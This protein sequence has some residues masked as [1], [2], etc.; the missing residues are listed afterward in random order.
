MASCY[1]GTTAIKRVVR[2]SGA[3]RQLKE[4]DG[5]TARSTTETMEN[6]VIVEA[7]T[8][9]AAQA[10]SG[11]GISSADVFA[12]GITIFVFIIVPLMIWAIRSLINEA[13][14]RTEDSMNLREIARSNKA[15]E[16]KLDSYMDRNDAEVVHVKE[17]IAAVKALVNI[18]RNGHGRST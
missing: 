5:F 1:D 14:R 2:A 11:G 18:S 3:F 12:A 17:D 10:A 15:V 7:A 6:T 16:Q 13:K 8:V 9:A 4:M